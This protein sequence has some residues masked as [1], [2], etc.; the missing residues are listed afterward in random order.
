MSDYLDPAN[1]ELL[2][3]FFMEAQAQID[4]LERN[5][6]VL[7]NEPTN[8]D[9]IDEIF[10]A[11]HTLKGNS[12]AV[13]MLEIAEFTHQMEDLLDEIR[14]GKASATS[15]VI[16]TMLDAIDIVKEMVE[17][18]MAGEIYSEDY[19]LVKDKLKSFM[20]GG[21]GRSVSQPKKEPPKQTAPAAPVQKTVQA[22]PPASGAAENKKLTE[23]E[24]LEL[25]ESIQKDEIIYN[26]QVAFNKDNPMNTIGGV[27]VFAKLKEIAT[28]LMTKPDFDLLYEDNYFPVV[29]YFV[30]T[31]IPKDQI[32]QKVKLADVTD[33]VIV[34]ELKRSEGGSTIAAKPQ[35]VEAFEPPEAYETPAEAAVTEAKSPAADTEL[36]DFDDDKSRQQKTKKSSGTESTVLKV[37][38]K[39]IDNLL[40][41]VSE[42]VINK[43]T[44]NQITTQFLG[45]LSDINSKYAKMNEVVYGIYDNMEKHLKD[46]SNGKVLKKDLFAEYEKVKADTYSIESSLKNTITKLVNTAQNFGRITNELHEG[47]LQIRM[48]PIGQIFSRFPRLVRDV[49]KKLNKKIQL[50]IEGEETELD[51]SVIEQLLDPLIHLVRNSMDHGV[52]MPADRAANNKKEE[53]TIILR[54]KNE[55]NMILIE[56]IDDGKG[57]DVDIVREKAISRGIIHPGKNLTEVEAFNLIFEPG[58]S[59]A[60]QISDISGRGVGL[61][62]VRKSIDKL[63]GSVNVWSK[64]GAG[65]TT[66]IR[67]PLTL[68]IIQGFLVR[69]GKEVYAIPITAVIE[70]QR[71][72]ADEIKYLDNYEVFDLREDVVSLM[73]LNRL[74]G[75]PTDEDKNTN[76]IVVVGSGDK[77]IGLMVDQL[78]GEEDVVIKPLK[79]KY[80]GV[81]G[82]A[83]ATILGDGQVSLIL[84]I[85][86]ILELCLSKERAAKKDKISNY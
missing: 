60:K 78:I 75:I 40:N 79:D 18:R 85:N 19:K 42:T 62:V 27:Q 66:S 83:G 44:F 63:N 53:G 46:D 45:V 16:D 15:E 7:E 3:D 48:V 54:A 67:L 25:F 74:F 21:S 81:Q 47:V 11:A 29:D 70:S 30:T 24:M 31:T 17:S 56:I 32:P 9:S 49:S 26:V 71:I 73:R 41:L 33:D 52:E 37:D 20:A 72:M 8:R 38:S 39:R 61:D 23:Y 77:K 65:T 80:T 13:E 5:I 55:G 59:T 69:V 68:A 76:Y 22:P 36:A 14:A 34:T 2:K 57:I 51:K 86:Q 50:V 82:I 43:A 1:E 35:E 12:G 84:D 4:I 28:V 6:L 64:K 58:F 10:R